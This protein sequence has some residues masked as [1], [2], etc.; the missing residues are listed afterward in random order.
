MNTASSFC[1]QSMSGK[2]MTYSDIIESVWG[3]FAADDR[4]I[5]RV[6]MANIRKKIEGDPAEPKYIVTEIGVGYRMAAAQ[7]KNRLKPTVN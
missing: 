2:V 4:Q 3:H 7:S 6:N 1:W 5:L